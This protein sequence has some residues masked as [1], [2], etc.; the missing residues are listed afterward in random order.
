MLMELDYLN[1]PPNYVKSTTVVN[2]TDKK[3]DPLKD[4]DPSLFPAMEVRVNR[5]K[6][7]DQPL[8]RWSFDVLP[9]KQGVDFRNIYGEVSGFTMTGATTTDGGFL[10]W[11]VSH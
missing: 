1:W 5:L 3:T 11:H 8:G 6:V 4:L 9:D 7:L 2:D 10:R